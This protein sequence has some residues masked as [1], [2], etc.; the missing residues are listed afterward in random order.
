MIDAVLD[1]SAEHLSQSATFRGWVGAADATAALAFIV[2]ADNATTLTTSHAV[3]D[4]P[5]LRFDTA[6]GMVN[7]EGSVSAALLIKPQ[8]S[9]LDDNGVVTAAAI[10]AMNAAAGALMSELLQWDDPRRDLLLLNLA[11][12]PPTVLASADDLP[13]WF[14]IGLDW[15]WSVRP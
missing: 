4:A 1:L 6:G 12:D 14:L 10:A 8:E 13:Q 11:I 3:I 2:K 15:T 5:P 7:G 9:D